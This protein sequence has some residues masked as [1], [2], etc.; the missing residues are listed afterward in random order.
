MVRDNGTQFIAGRIDD[1]Y[2]ELDIDHMTSSMSYPQGNG[3]MEV[4]NRVI[5]KGVKKRLQ[6]EG[7]SW[8]QELPTVLSSLRTTLNPITRE[9]PFSLVYGY[10]ALMPVEM[11]A[12]TTR[13][14]CYEELA[15]EHRS[16]KTQKIGVSVRG[17]L[18]HLEDSGPVTYELETL[19]RRQVPRSSNACHL[20]KYYV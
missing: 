15:N 9:T 7:G 2:T 18:Y 5:F 13:V 8:H 11:Y 19:E 14:T 20:R 3:Q 17:T 4:M 16:W 10:D 12:D 6:Q 1:L